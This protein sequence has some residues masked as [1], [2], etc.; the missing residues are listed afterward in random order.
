MRRRPW[1]ALLGHVRGIQLQN[2]PVRGPHGR[3]EQR[4]VAMPA[5]FDPDSH[6]NI[7]PGQPAF[8]QSE[9]PVQAPSGHLEVHRTQQ[10]MPGGIGDRQRDR[11]LANVDSNNNG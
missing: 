4:P 7:H 3:G 8:D 6:G 5:S 2:L 11:P 9:D 1:T 10:A